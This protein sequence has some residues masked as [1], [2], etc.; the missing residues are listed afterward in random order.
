MLFPKRHAVFWADVNL[1][2]F[3]TESRHH[4]LGLVRVLK[5]FVRLQKD[6]VDQFQEIIVAIIGE[7][8]LGLN[9]HRSGDE[10]NE[11]HLCVHEAALLNLEERINLRCRR[12]L[13]NLCLY[14]FKHLVYL[15]NV[16][17]VTIMLTFCYDSSIRL[18]VKCPHLVVWYKIILT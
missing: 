18:T 9:G 4:F 14:S 10:G 3:Q 7:E 15:I 1:L 8:I 5:Q 13:S 11:G 12:I 2:I 6:T 16:P 17:H